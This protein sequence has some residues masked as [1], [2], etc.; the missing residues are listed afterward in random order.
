MVSSET[1]SAVLC[2][3]NENYLGHSLIA[4]DLG[5]SLS[6][7]EIGSTFQGAMKEFRIYETAM[8]A[9]TFTRNTNSKML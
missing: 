3:C 9:E 5:F 2:F 4:K 6:N 1:Q 8:A 7:F